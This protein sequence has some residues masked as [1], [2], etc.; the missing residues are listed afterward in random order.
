MLLVGKIFRRKVN[1]IGTILPGQ[2][3]GT[4]IIARLPFWVNRFT[5]ACVFSSR[6]Y[7]LTIEMRWQPGF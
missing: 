5:I 1:Y 6:S 2:Y 4:P 3:R 7:P